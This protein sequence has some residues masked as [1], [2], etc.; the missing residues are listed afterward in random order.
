[1]HME[2]DV[3]LLSYMAIWWQEVRKQFR[4]NALSLSSSKWFSANTLKC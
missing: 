4:W 3:I 1:M 2:G